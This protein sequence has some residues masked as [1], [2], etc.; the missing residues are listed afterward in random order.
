ML[1]MNQILRSSGSMCINITHFFFYDL[2]YFEKTNVKR[3][4]NLFE[5]LDREEQKP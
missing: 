2:R 4:K 3:K 5:F 1:Y